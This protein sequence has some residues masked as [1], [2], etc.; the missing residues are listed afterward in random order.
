[1]V[2]ECNIAGLFEVGFEGIISANITGSSE[3]VDIVSQCSQSPNVFSDVR[4]RLKGPSTGNLSI[5]AYA[6]PQGGD[7][8]LGISCPSQAGVS[9]PIQSRFDCENN[10]TRLIRTKTGEAFRE[11]DT[12]SGITL[13]EEFCSFRTINAS[14]AS[15]P[16][17]QV[18]DTT[19]F[20]G[21]DLI[22]TGPPFAFDT[23]NAD[24]LDFNI[25]GLDVKLTN[26]SISITLPSPATN[27]Y[28]FQF[29]IPSC[30]GTLI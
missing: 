10:I 7:R 24:S 16:A 9:L 14:A 8:Y 1:M 4:K 12:I 27:Q 15:G 6:F 19:R 3:F 26:F 28:T 23:Q 22:W 17:S 25:L 13:L 11:G 18:V 21:S 30:E 5:T 2:C 20:L 29:S